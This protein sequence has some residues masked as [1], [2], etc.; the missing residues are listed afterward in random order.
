LSDQH[1]V[2]VQPIEPIFD[3]TDERALVALLTETWKDPRRRIALHMPSIQRVA[4]IGS[5]TM[6][7]GI[8]QVM[9]TAGFQT[10]VYDVQQAAL[11][12]AKAQVEKQLQAAVEKGKLGQDEQQLALS[13]LSFSSN[14][15]DV[16]ADF[17]IEAILEDLDVKV[18]LFQR[19]AAQN[20]E[21]AIFATIYIYHP[22]YTVGGKSESSGAGSWN[23]F[24]QSGT[25]DEIG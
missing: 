3:A 23:A 8:A 18:D 22:H 5:G 12:R 17:L 11:E 25:C 1:A 21:H 9:A 2:W 13:K 20:S 7:L 15:S 24:F 6:G 4:V 10:I 19:L 14:F 16:V